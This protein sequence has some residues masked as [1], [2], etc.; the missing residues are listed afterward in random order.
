MHIFP[1]RARYGPEKEIGI[2][3]EMTIH[4]KELV[5]FLT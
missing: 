4:K 1:S 5:I 3:K 2:R